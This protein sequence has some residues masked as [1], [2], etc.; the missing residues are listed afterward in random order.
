M[1]R[2][3]NE[4]QKKVSGEIHKQFHNQEIKVRETQVLTM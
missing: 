4:K 1:W 2:C 3:H